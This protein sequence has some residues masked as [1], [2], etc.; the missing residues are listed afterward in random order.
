MTDEKKAPRIYGTP[1]PG[2]QLPPA[3]EGLRGEGA[4]H[5]TEAKPDQTRPVDA[6]GRKIEVAETS[7]TASAESKGAADAAKSD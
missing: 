7:G 4:P 2:K 1:E 6:D 3:T 5:L